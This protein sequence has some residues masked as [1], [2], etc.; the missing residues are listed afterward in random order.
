MAYLHCQKVTRISIWV[1]TSMPKNGK[2]Q[3]GIRVSEFGLGSKNVAIR[4]GIRGG[5]R[6]RQWKYPIILYR[7]GTVNSNTVNLK[8][9]LI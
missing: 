9:H 4:F 5:I 3:L 6:I 8:F 2:R 7:S 1:R